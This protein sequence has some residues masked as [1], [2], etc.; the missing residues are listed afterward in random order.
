MAHGPFAQFAVMTTANLTQ[1]AARQMPDRL[2]ALR[3]FGVAIT[4]LTV[5]GHTVFG[6]EQAWIA[7]LVAI[8]T[9]YTMELIF[10][11]LDAMANRRQPTYKGGLVKLV[12]FLLPAHITGLAIAL[13]LYPGERVGPLVFACVVAISSK[14]VLRA[15]RPG[16]KK[17]F[18]NPSN[19]GIAITLF[20]FPAVGIA[21]PYHFTERIDGVADWILP[22][23]IV[24]TGTFLNARFTRRLPLIAA[25][26]VGFAAQAA[27]RSS[28]F[29]TSLA[30]SLV[31]MTGVA[32]VLFTF[33]MVTDPATT[34][35]PGLRQVAFG[36]TV[37][38]TYGL[39]MTVHV[40]FGLFFSLAIVCCIRGAFMSLQAARIPHARVDVSRGQTRMSGNPAYA[41]NAELGFV[42]ARSAAGDATTQ[43]E[44]VE[45]E[46]TLVQ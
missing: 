8:A 14:Y 3:R 9:T 40:A 28:V 21:P 24:C 31:P 25:W 10:A 32:F 35:V 27:V 6:F 38:A 12:D 15:G 39:L 2:G 41:A 7:P 33:Y 16:H 1:T 36:G 44:P 29:E 11:T 19:F 42:V 13:L 4:I 30:A 26:V 18:L 5:L 22:L 37:A 43:R 34:P 17:H 20:L 46:A 45:R 23:V